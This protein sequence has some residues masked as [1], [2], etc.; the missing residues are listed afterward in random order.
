MRPEDTPESPL[1]CCDRGDALERRKPKKDPVG[2]ISRSFF[3][4][5]DAHATI[6]A[7]LVPL[8]DEHGV[9]DR[10]RVEVRL[11]IDGARLGRY[12]SPP[13]IRGEPVSQQLDRAALGRHAHLLQGFAPDHLA[14]EPRIRRLLK[15]RRRFP[16]QMRDGVKY[17]TTIF[18]PDG[19]HV[20]QDTSYPWSC[21]GR[22]ETNL[23]PFSGVL[24]GPRHLLTCNHGIDWTPPPG[25]AADWLTFT[26]SYFDGGAPFGSTYATHIY[27]VKKDNNNG[28]SDGDEGQYD[29]TVLVLNDRIG[30]AT[31]WWGT[32]SYADAWDGN[33]NWWHIGYPD[34][35][36]SMQR[37]IYVNGF[38]MDGA[39]D[40]DDAH[41]EIYH[42]GDVWPGQSGGPMF[43]FWSGDPWPSAV[44]VQSWQNSET[45][46]ASG[47]ASLVDLVIRARSDF[48]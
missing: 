40:Q 15:A 17:N 14:V 22:C 37:P 16:L 24:V 48:P 45:N 8:E 20:F 18:A 25:Y 2:R 30:E 42:K 9:G 5:A 27:W 11:E 46:G 7:R 34:D 39:D 26:P 23:G 43:G 3:I 33:P 38:T 21:I 44:A 29:Y 10:R 35:L 19:R 1:D 31:G 41:E 36:T 4:E 13:G 32:K 12:A 6:A 28:T 47:G